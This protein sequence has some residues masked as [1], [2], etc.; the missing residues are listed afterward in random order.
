MGLARDTMHMFGEQRQGQIQA[1]MIMRLGL[2]PA[3][4]LLG[5]SVTRAADAP[6]APLDLV[7]GEGSN[8]F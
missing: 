3:I 7:T 1:T 4:T 8:L 2:V 6:I 5:L